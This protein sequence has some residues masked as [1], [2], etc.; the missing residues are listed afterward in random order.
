MSAGQGRTGQGN[1]S[2]PLLDWNGRLERLNYQTGMMLDE[3][4][5]RDEQTF[6]R[7]SLALVL[8]HALGMGTLA[9]L[10]VAMKV[11]PNPEAQLNVFPGVAID[12]RGRLISLDATQKIRLGLWIA[13]QHA[14]E[15]ASA[16]TANILVA[17]VFL[18]LRPHASQKTPVLASGPY[19]A[20]DA[21][22]PA[23]LENRAHLELLLRKEAA[24]IP[25]PE[26]TWPTDETGRRDAVLGSVPDQGEVLDNA[27]MVPLREH[28]MGQDVSAV[29]LARLRIPVRMGADKHEIDPSAT[30]DNIVDLSIG[31]PVIALDG[32]WVGATPTV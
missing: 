24:P 3:Q 31:R 17:D 14:D 7:A 16:V 26:N 8:R 22:A 4:D 32:K 23:R 1:G 6:H 28:I 20:L 15:L 13:Q 18:S 2:D 10:R 12:R 30:I 29:F 21:V 25:A 19:D 5:M 11:G 9:G 27:Q